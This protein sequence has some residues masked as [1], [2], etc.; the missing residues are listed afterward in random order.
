[1]PSEVSP[2]Y[3]PEPFIQ[4]SIKV[5]FRFIFKASRVNFHKMSKKMV[6]KLFVNVSIEV[7]EA[8]KNSNYHRN[9]S[10][11]DQLFGILMF[12]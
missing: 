2:F 4:A 3:E 6:A 5:R 9:L 8:R 11:F 1:M 7:K 10:I 12:R